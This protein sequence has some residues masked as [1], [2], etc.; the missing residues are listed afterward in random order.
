M[1]KPTLMRAKL[2]TL[3]TYNEY[4]GKVIL[5]VKDG[6]K[7]KRDWYQKKADQWWSILEV[8]D[9]AVNLET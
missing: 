3:E 2:V 7:Y 5:A 4:L 9:F 6:D 1:G 8:I